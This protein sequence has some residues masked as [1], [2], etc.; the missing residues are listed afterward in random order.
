MC[1]LY[2]QQIVEQTNYIKEIIMKNDKLRFGVNY[3]PSKKWLYSW[4]DWDSAAIL[5]DLQT[6][7]AMGMDHIRAH[8]LWPVF[9]PNRAYLSVTSM[10]RLEELFALAESCK[11]DVVVT[12]LTGWICGDL[13]YPAWRGQ[14]NV[15]T[16]RTMIEA[17]KFLLSGIAARVGKRPNFLGFDMG[18]E[19]NILDF[20]PNGSKISMEEGDRW[21]KEIMAH[22]ETVAPGKMHVNGVDHNPWF[23]DA[24]FSRHALSN[25]G[26][27]TSLH[28]W[29][30]FTGA[31]EISK[32]SEIPC[33]HLAEYSVELANAY[34]ENP[35]RPVWIEEF[36]ANKLWMPEEEMPW[37]AEQMIRNAATCKNTWGFTWWCSHDIDR[38]YVGFDPLEYEMGLIDIHNGI[39]P[40]GTRI[41]KLIKE[42]KE[43]PPEVIERTV[44]LVLPDGFMGD[45]AGTET[46][47]PYPGW[48]F[49]KPYFQL[50]QE[51]IRPAIVLE[52]R[53]D[54]KAYLNARG[55]QELRF[56]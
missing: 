5:D 50:I 52:S 14:A 2:R 47:K 37:F 26:Q 46:A 36:G 54:D 4:V 6:I 34:S 11:L 27:A 51:G 43:N 8:L 23:K 28:T 38:A 45:M 55:I 20:S 1:V 7:A 13:H 32:T 17:E 29:I 3:T 18:N 53:S 39:K 48:A 24:S 25:L 10:D 16:D 40:V 15:F 30:L 19:I 35:D 33:T 56:I 22:C 49:A 31:M 12:T 21:L 42:F 9:Q 44:A 41:S